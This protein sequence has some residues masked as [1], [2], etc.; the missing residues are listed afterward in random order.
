[1]PVTKVILSAAGG[2]SRILMKVYEIK[3][4]LFVIADLLPN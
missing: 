4:N 2:Y 1:M 3:Y